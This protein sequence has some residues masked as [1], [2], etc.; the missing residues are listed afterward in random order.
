MDF[1][2][3]AAPPPRAQVLCS[4]PE[5]LAA[6]A[7]GPETVDLTLE[8][9][10]RGPPRLLILAAAAAALYYAARRLG[11]QL[12]GLVRNLSKSCPM[13]ALLDLMAFALP[14]FFLVG[15]SRME[16]EARQPERVER[17]LTPAEQRNLTEWDLA[18]MAGRM[19]DGNRLEP[20]HRL[21]LEDGGTALWDGEAWKHD[22]TGE[23][24]KLLAS[25][26][27]TGAATRW[28]SGAR[29]ESAGSSDEYSELTDPD[30]DEPGD[31]F[32]TENE[33][34]LMRVYEA[35]REAIYWEDP[36]LGTLMNFAKFA[37]FMNW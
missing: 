13:E 27:S 1:T 16:R 31:A 22:S 8:E 3:C 36:R 15:L 28:S 19:L 11:P 9:P 25:A 33:R 30:P 14:I 17:G 20:G 10:A 2:D 18:L 29:A 34:S 6:P 32:A 5:I 12:S 23:P 4:E 21:K 7:R 37:E 35:L 26:T 24:M